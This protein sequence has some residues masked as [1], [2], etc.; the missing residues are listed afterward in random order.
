MIYFSDIELS[1]INAEG[2]DEEN[3]V[4]KYVI[5]FDDNNDVSKLYRKY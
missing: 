2:V 5:N 1:L 3:D 4:F